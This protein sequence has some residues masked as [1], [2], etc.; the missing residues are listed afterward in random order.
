MEKEIAGREGLKIPL[1]EALLREGH[2][3]SRA[4]FSDER[5]EPQT[6]LFNVVGHTRHG[7]IVECRPVEAPKARNSRI[8][9]RYV[10]YMPDNLEDAEALAR[11]PGKESPPHFK[12]HIAPFAAYWL[13]LVE[14]PH[15]SQVTAQHGNFAYRPKG[16]GTPPSLPKATRSRQWGAR[17]IVFEYLFRQRAFHALESL[18]PLRID[19]NMDN[20]D[21]RMPLELNRFVQDVRS[22]VEGVNASPHYEEITHAEDQRRKKGDIPGARIQL[23]LPKVATPR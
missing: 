23:V 18:G 4:H 20:A 2:A 6:L 14:S 7:R 5:M 17:E 19:L 22:A 1:A 8:W 21:T 15:G 9:E 12:R 13:H 11:A 3:T 10:F 16:R